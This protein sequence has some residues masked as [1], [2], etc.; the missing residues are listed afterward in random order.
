MKE[1]RLCKYGEIILKGANKGHFEALLMR[2]IRRRAKH[3]GNF[4]VSYAQ[5]T[6]FIEPLD[7]E[8]IEATVRFCPSFCRARRS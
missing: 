7:D 8:A 6:V 4:E 1:I 3:I 5:S 2:D